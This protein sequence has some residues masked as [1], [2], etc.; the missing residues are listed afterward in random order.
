MELLIRSQ[1][2]GADKGGRAG[3]RQ[4]GAGREANWR[5]KGEEERAA[6]PQRGPSR[7]EGPSPSVEALGPKM[8]RSP[9]PQ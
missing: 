3:D 7:G 5:R 9:P 4:R 1:R 2:R 8:A 6:E